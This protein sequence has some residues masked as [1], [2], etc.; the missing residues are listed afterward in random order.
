[1]DTGWP[2]RAYTELLPP[3]VEGEDDGEDDDNEDADYT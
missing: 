1:M 3:G 2:V